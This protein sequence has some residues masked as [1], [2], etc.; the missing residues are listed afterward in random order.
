MRAVL[1]VAI[2]GHAE[3]SDWVID[4]VSIA[5]EASE[6]AQGWTSAPFGASTGAGL[7]AS[8]FA[9][10][11]LGVLSA[12]TGVGILDR[13][14]PTIASKDLP[15]PPALF[16]WRTSNSTLS[17]C[18]GPVVDQ[19]GAQGQKC[20]SCWAV[21]VTETFSDRRC[22]AERQELGS[23]SA[24]LELSA[25][26]LIACDRKCEHF[27]RQCNMGCLGGYPEIAWKYLVDDGLVSADC[28]PYNLTKQMLCPL[29][30]CRPPLEPTAHKAKRSFKIYGGSNAIRRELVRAGPVQA[31]F[32]VF[33]D[34]LSYQ[35]GVYRHVSGRQLGLHAVKVIGYS[36][37]TL[38]NGTAY[39]TA[40]NSWG[41]SFG[42]NGTF[43]I[44]EGECDFEL[45][46]MA[47]DALVPGRR[48]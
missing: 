47:G 39:W 21:S 19:D 35:S 25:L 32:T 7:Q 44:A 29:P 13:M 6:K 40:M 27:H 15:S 14:E 8:E 46:V 16:D 22:I 43:M 33:E 24:R 17:E 31:V 48:A 20:G 37:G 12:E 23:K 2:A 1:L 38:T 10:R 9:S 42:M 11:F 34:F 18:I 4:P 28:M 36:N 26:D 5:G 3:A 41:P 30:K 45:N